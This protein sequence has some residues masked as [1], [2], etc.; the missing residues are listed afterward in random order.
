M[1]IA[2]HGLEQVLILVKSGSSLGMTKS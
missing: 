2:L 1:S